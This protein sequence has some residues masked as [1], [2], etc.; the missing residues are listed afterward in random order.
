RGSTT[1]G[2][3]AAG[4]LGPDGDVQISLVEPAAGVGGAVPAL[5]RDG[6]DVV[7]LLVVEDLEVGG[8]EVVADLLGGAAEVDEPVGAVIEHGHRPPPLRLR[9]SLVE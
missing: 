2:S 1:A 3:R 6:A 4:Q 8:D 5:Q 7:A 9:F